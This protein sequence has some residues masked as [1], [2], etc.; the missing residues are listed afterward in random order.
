LPAGLILVDKPAGI[1]SSQVTGRV[2][3]LLRSRGGKKVKVGHFG[4][5]DPFATGLLPLAIGE[6]T[7]LLSYLP[8]SPKVYEF[9]VAWGV[10]TDTGDLTGQVVCRAP[11]RPTA[12]EILAVLP[13]F[14][15]PILQIPPRFSALHVNGRRAYEL[16]REGVAFSL[17]PRRQVIDAL[18]L[19]AAE[20]HQATFRVRCDGGTYVRVLGEDLARALG[21]CGHLTSLRRLQVGPWHVN[22]ASPL[23]SFNDLGHTESCWRSFFISLR[24]MLDDIPAVE[25]CEGN[26]QNLRH[27]RPIPLGKQVLGLVACVTGQK[28]VA[29]AEPRDGFLHPVRVFK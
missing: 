7:R 6:G 25:V 28:L 3:W 19:E 9:V 16:A 12:P 29:L 5:L 4:T 23:D 2:G 24:D 21:T 18:T 17:P 1:G 26:Q 15:G 22:A 8:S 20:A 10:E 27:G 13:R 11:G 14:H